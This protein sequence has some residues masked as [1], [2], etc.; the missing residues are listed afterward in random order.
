MM[1]FV[2]KLSELKKYDLT[3]NKMREYIN[4]YKIPLCDQD[5]EY[6]GESLKN[7]QVI[8]Y[9]PIKIDENEKSTGKL[10]LTDNRNYFKGNNFKVFNCIKLTFSIEGQKN[11]L[12]SE[13]FILL[14]ILNICLIIITEINYDKNFK[15]L[16]NYC[17]DKN[18]KIIEIINKI[19]QNNNNIYYFFGS[20]LLWRI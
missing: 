3:L 18:N 16:L 2:I 11:N 9:C 8:C 19:L 13:I 12:F 17:K 14:F 10:F 15:E 4:E 5:C 20:K 6:E 1:I 7:F